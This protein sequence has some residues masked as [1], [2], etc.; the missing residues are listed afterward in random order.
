MAFRKRFKLSDESINTYGWWI[1]LSGM[2]LTGMQKNAPLYYNHRTWEIPCGH[3]ENIEL[4]DGNVYGDIVIEGGNDI[5]REYIRKIENGDIKGC[6]LGI[7]PIEWSTDPVNIK[8]GQTM[9]TLTKCCPYEVSL[10][11]LPAN[12]NALVLKHKNDIITLSTGVKYDFIP[13]LNLKKDMKKIAIQLGMADTAT[14][15]QICDALQK[16]Q[17]KA[18]SVDALHKVIEESIGGD[19]L[20]AEQ[21]AFFVSLS[22]TDM[23]AALQFLNLS[24][25]AAIVPLAELVVP[26]KVLTIAGL[27]KLG[28]EGAEAE[29]EGKD[30]F[31]YLQKHNSV[32][33]GRIRASE[34]EKYKTLVA[35]YAE[36]VRY[37]A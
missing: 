13:D 23:P 34:P 1:Q 24:K 20:P 14:E 3:V 26:A 8:Q 19:D 18:N 30:S 21:K 31:D 7:D 27:I 16:V 32:E 4:K 11:P 28:K 12:K 29:K 35:G 5:E 37:K 33:L 6:S 9:A 2:D 15:E 10:T 36:G 25:K 22:K 17:L